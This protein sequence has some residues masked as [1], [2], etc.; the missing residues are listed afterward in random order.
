MM[1]FSFSD[2][3]LI[4]WDD[5]GTVQPHDNR[6]VLTNNDGQ[7]KNSNITIQ[8]SVAFFSL[9]VFLSVALERIRPSS[10]FSN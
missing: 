2:D 1:L 8:V 5:D 6:S 9:S 7:S 10:T 3:V 4:N